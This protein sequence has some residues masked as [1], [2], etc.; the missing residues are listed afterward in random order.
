MKST[1]YNMYLFRN[2][3]SRKSKDP[4]KLPDQA[5]APGWKL[6]GKVPPKQTAQ[7]DASRISEEYQAKVKICQQSP[8]RTRKRDIEVLSTTALI[9]ENRPM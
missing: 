9:L 1:I 6:F 5:S 3:F 4:T 7:K 2:I 8:T